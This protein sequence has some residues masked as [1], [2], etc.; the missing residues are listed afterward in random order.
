MNKKKLV[1]GTLLSIVIIFTSVII[2]YIN[3]KPERVDM[4]NGQLKYGMQFPFDDLY[5]PVTD[6]LYIEQQKNKLIFLVSS[7]CKGCM[8]DLNILKMLNYIYSD[9]NLEVLLVWSEIFNNDFIE[10]HELDSIRN[11]SYIGDETIASQTPFFFLVDNNNKILFCDS[12]IDLL[13]EKLQ[14]MTANTK[15]VI[16]K[17]NE[18]LLSNYGNDKDPLFVYF[19]MEGCGDCE[20]ADQL[21]VEKELNNI[22]NIQRIYSYRTQ[23][24]DLEVDKYKILMKIYKITWYPSFLIL[25][26]DEYHFYGEENTKEFLDFAEILFVD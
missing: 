12:Q 1:V 2:Y 26:N 17:A 4:S 13:V 7:E 3:N 24:P 16:S 21:I 19:T 10:K 25:S 5:D 11:Y 14:D 20:F 15:D 9:D 18:Y 8:S 6:E 22:Y 23:N